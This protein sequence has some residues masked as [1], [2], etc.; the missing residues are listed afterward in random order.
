[1]PT[2]SA[3]P[4]PRGRSGRRRSEPDGEHARAGRHTAR[5]CSPG[6]DPAGALPRGRMTERFAARNWHKPDVE[7]VLVALILGVLAGQRGGGQEIRTPEGLLPPTRF[8]TMLAS[9]HRRT[10][11]SVSWAD[12]DGWVWA[13]TREPRR[14]RPHLRPAGPAG[15][16]RPRRLR[17]LRVAVWLGTSRSWLGYL[18]GPACHAGP[19]GGPAGQQVMPGVEPHTRWGDC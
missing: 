3:P 9:V 18:A 13:G 11:S 19:P 4:A 1:M 15:R 16:C 14:M 17:R 7:T 8:P 5:L 6:R 10:P 12:C 2:P